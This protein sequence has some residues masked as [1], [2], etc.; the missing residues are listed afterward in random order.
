M[1]IGKEGQEK[2]PIE[3]LLTDF[4]IPREPA[5]YHC[6][7]RLLGESLPIYFTFQVNEEYCIKTEDF[8]FKEIDSINKLFFSKEVK[9]NKLN[10]L[11]AIYFEK[12][13]ENNSKQLEEM[14][15]IY[16][17]FGSNKE[18]NKEENKEI[19]FFDKK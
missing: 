1:I 11:S 13:E 8:N 2:R 15:Q 17:Y 4:K 14:I 7:Y 12:I 16:S 5:I 6:E 9:S 19:D 10:T 3:T 18:E